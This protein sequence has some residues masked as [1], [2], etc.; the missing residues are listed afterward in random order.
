MARK[1]RRP[2]PRLTLFM[3]AA[4][5]SRTAVANAAH[6]LVAPAVIASSD[7]D[8]PVANPLPHVHNDL[9]YSNGAA[10]C[11]CG[12]H[13]TGSDTATL[14][15]DL[16]D[17]ADVLVVELDCLGRII[18]FNGAVSRLSGW[19][20]Q[21]KRGHDWVT[22]FVPLPEREMTRDACMGAAERQEPANHRAALIMRDG[23]CRS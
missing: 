1:S 22:D 16:L 14:L 15:N 8:L 3:R 10:P 9:A 6:R 12:M 18:W 7:K 4:R 2:I 5:K 19:S 17:T 11:G 13:T 23:T 20:L 21:E